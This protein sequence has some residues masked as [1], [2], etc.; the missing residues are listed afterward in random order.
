M[1]K[2]FVSCTVNREKRTYCFTDTGAPRKEVRHEF[3]DNYAVEGGVIVTD[4]GRG[5]IARLAGVAEVLGFLANLRAQ[6]HSYRVEE[7]E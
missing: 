1:T 4:G 3:S 5:Y 7:N 6:I 2:T